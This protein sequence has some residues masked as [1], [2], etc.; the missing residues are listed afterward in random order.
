MYAGVSLFSIFDIIRLFRITEWIMQTFLAI[1]F[2]IIC[3]WHIRTR[4]HIVIVDWARFSSDLI[5]ILFCFTTSEAT[6][7]KREKETHAYTS[8][9][10]N[11]SEYDYLF[12]YT[13]CLSPKSDVPRPSL[14]LIHW[15]TWAIFGWYVFLIRLPTECK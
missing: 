10:S 5:D 12:V 4:I 8:I 13:L 2:N 3:V 7:E 14:F 6:N 11:T 15:G 9:E 1:V